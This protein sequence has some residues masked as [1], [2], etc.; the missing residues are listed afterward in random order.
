MGKTAADIAGSSGLRYDAL[1]RFNEAA[2]SGPTVLAK[3]AA[4]IQR[5]KSLERSRK[6]PDSPCRSP[7]RGSPGSEHADQKVRQEELPTEQQKSAEDREREFQALQRH[8]QTLNNDVLAKQSP[9][10]KVIVP[11][12]SK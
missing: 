12:G 11:Q 2:G 8:M 5:T 1:A 7:L 4:A 9:K 3:R 6:W 10:V